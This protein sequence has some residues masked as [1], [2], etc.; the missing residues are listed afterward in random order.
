MVDGTIY[1]QESID[2]NNVVTDEGTQPSAS[3]CI[4][5]SIKLSI[6]HGHAMDCFLS[7][8]RTGLLVDDT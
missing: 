4:E 7:H 1:I 8:R 2:C 3:I 5:H 6:L